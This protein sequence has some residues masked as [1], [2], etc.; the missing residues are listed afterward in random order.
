MCAVFECDFSLL[1]VG[2]AAPHLHLGVHELVVEGGRVDG[3]VPVLWWNW[4]RAA[5]TTYYTP[6]HTAAPSPPHFYSAQVSGKSAATAIT[7][8]TTAR[9][10]V[11][12]LQ[13]QLSRASSRSTLA[14]LRNTGVVGTSAVTAALAEVERQ[15]QLIHT[16]LKVCAVYGIGSC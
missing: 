8:V 7:A 10:D 13:T 12:T 6:A 16:E 3:C 14:V 4:H 15:R 9:T 11:R 2:A 1:F 5:C